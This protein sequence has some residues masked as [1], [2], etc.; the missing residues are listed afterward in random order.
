MVLMRALVKASSVR[1]RTWWPSS[2]R[3]LPPSAWMAIDVERRGHL[4]ARGR[5]G[6]HLAGVGHLR[7]LVRQGEQA[8]GLAAHRAD[9]DDDAVARALRRDGPARDVA[10]ALDRADRRATE[11]LDDEGH[12]E[13]SL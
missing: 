8:V 3:A 5:D 11:L 6:V 1:M 10:Y 12:G 2:E 13:A 4:L 9:D 7:H